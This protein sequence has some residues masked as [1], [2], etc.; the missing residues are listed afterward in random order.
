MPEDAGTTLP[1]TIE[2]SCSAAVDSLPHSHGTLGRYLLLRVLGHGGFGVV[3]EA[4]D[5]VLD[6][7]IAVKLLMPSSALRGQ[8]VTEAQA[9]AR[10]H[11][12]NV[13]SVF[14]A[15]VQKAGDHE[16]AYVAMELVVGGTLKQW[17]SDGKRGLGEILSRYLLAAHGLEAAHEVGLVHRDFKPS[18]VLLGDD[19]RV[20]VSDFGLAL[21]G[22]A[23]A[24]AS[25]GAARDGSG[26]T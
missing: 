26:P 19:G 25:G 9:L 4:Y 16:L 18:N 17:L 14:D 22:G 21:V 5:P 8:I 11:H 12:A 10:V 6:R 1:S 7:K 2:A 23:A 13:V 15:G 20:R 3:W 24:A